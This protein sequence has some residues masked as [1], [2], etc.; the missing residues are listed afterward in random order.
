MPAVARDTPGNLPSDLSAFVGRRRELEELRSLLTDS[1]L[2]TL[3]K[4]RLALRVASTMPRVFPDG[5]WFV[6]PTELQDG[7]LLA[8]ELHSPTRWRTSS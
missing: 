1:R 5:A 4:T 8:Q 2:V 3:N 7:V 6:D